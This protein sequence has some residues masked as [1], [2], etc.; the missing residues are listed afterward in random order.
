M[1]TSVEL[2]SRQVVLSDREAGAIRG[3]SGR[4]ADRVLECVLVAD[5]GQEHAAR[6]G[7]DEW[8]LR[9]WPGRRVLQRIPSC[10]EAAADETGA[11][12]ADGCGCPA[13]HEGG[14]AFASPPE[15]PGDPAGPSV[16]A[17]GV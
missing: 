5:H 12:R 7:G 9:W 4:A 15:G 17:G 10:G 2:C 8:W 3:L 11:A 1:T 6:T 16:R 14:H 13:G